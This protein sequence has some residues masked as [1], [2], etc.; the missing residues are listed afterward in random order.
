MASRAT[1]RESLRVHPA[2]DVF[3]LFSKQQLR[4]LADDIEQNGLKAGVV[5]YSETLSPVGA[6]LLDGRNRLD[7]L[8]LLGDKIFDAAGDVKKEW[9][10]K[11]LSLGYD[12]VAYVISANIR[13]RHLTKQQQADLIV[14]AVKAGKTHRAK[15]ARWVKGQTGSTKDPVKAQVIE[16]AAKA[17]ISER[18]A[19]QALVDAEPER[20]RPKPGPRKTEGEAGR[21]A[22]RHARSVLRDSTPEQLAEIIQDLPAERRAAIVRAAVPPPDRTPG[23]RTG[24]TFIALVVRTSSSLIELASLVGGWENPA[25]IPAEFSASSFDDIA[26]KAMRIKNTVNSLRSADNDEF[27]KIARNFRVTDDAS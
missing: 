4:E 7:A 16:E 14:A 17:G 18:T 9:Y 20:K 22:A 27:Q 8:E 26:E 2:A 10:E 12:P 3:P 1:W 13:R 19:T 11:T 21:V 15:S 25:A 23:Q 5:L 24:P 6:V